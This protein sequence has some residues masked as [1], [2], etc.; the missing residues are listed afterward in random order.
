ML[1]KLRSIAYFFKNQDWI[2]ENVAD[3]LF[4]GK[5]GDHGVSYLLDGSP[6][7]DET[8]PTHDGYPEHY[9]A[10]GIVPWKVLGYL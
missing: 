1:Q 3:M 8:S 9:H 6:D 4:S 5:A 2:S 10:T 7:L